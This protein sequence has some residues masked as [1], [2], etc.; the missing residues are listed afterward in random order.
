MH[1]LKRTVRIL[2][3]TLLSLGLAQFFYV[4]LD[5]NVFDYL[6]RQDGEADVVNLFY[7][8]GNGA[9][10]Y[11]QSIPEHDVAIFDLAGETSRSR[12]AAAVDRLYGLNPRKI[13]LDVIFPEAATVPPAESDSL[14]RVVEA[15]A[16]R[17]VTACRIVNGVQVEHSFYTRPLGIVC[18]AANNA[19]YYCRPEV[20][21]PD[22]NSLPALA[23]AATD[24]VALSGTD[25]Y[26]NFRNRAFGELG[27]GDLP[28][29][30]R[31]DVEGKI[32]IVGD[33]KDLR[34]YKDL[35][36]P[37]GGD[38]RVPG[39]ML[40]ASTVATILH[41]DWVVRSADWVGWTVAA[42]LT[43]LFV[44]L[45][46]QAGDKLRPASLGSLTIRLLKL[47]A[48][49]LL[50]LSTYLVFRGFGVIVNLMYAMIAIAMSGFALD[51]TDYGY[52]LFDLFRN[53]KKHML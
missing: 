42:L 38:W 19:L 41:D 7:R 24:S 3:A 36:F 23:Y 11:R 10:R 49:L 53:R 33:R 12:V 5:I 30:D 2:V 22:G 1:R 28:T 45:C 6:S 40:L 14:R 51:A 25:R 16:P 44:F 39:V 50:L 29:L 26:V 31:C 35:P 21:L 52:H 4:M 34:D 8:I 43:L 32:I 17:I 48:V 15:C 27:F 20:T 46:Y 9:E 47:L 37:I 13:V 18:G